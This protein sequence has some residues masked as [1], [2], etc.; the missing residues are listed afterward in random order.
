MTVTNDDAVAG[1]VPKLAVMP[2]GQFDAARVT[3]EL[4][5][6]AGVT[7]TVEAPVAPTIAVAEVALNVK[8]GAP[9]ATHASVSSEFGGKV[10]DDGPLS[11]VVVRKLVG[12]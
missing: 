10:K 5:P 9:P 11:V 6:L 1:L 4:K 12:L 8:L 3:P 2:A 7:V